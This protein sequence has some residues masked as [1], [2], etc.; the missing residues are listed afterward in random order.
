MASSSKLEL[1]SV[2]DSCIKNVELLAINLNL[3]MNAS[4]RVV[5]IYKPRQYVDHEIHES[6]YTIYFTYINVFN[7]I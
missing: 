7:L 6:Y 3:F 2:S 1:T 5:H 4:I